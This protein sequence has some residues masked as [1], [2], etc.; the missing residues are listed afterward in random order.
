MKNIQLL[1]YSD[2]LSVRPGES[3]SFKISSTLKKNLQQV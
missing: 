2:K 1:G 3:V